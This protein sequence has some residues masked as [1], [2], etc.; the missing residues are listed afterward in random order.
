L[1]SRQCGFDGI[2]VVPVGNHIPDPA[3]EWVSSFAVQ[4]GDLVSRARQLLNQQLSNEQRP[5]DYE[6]AHRVF[7]PWPSNAAFGPRHS[8]AAAAGRDFSRSTRVRGE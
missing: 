4:E 6:N 5:A 8:G 2:D 7:A 3:P 1:L